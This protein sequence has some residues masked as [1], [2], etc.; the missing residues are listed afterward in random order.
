[1]FLFESFC[2]SERVLARMS[3]GEYETE[4]ERRT[5]ARLKLMHEKVFE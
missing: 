3:G 1:M 5:S 2:V 4:Y